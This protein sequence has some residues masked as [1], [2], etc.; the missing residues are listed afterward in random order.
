MEEDSDVLKRKQ[1][2]ILVISE[3][4]MFLLVCLAGLVSRIS[5][6]MK[7]SDFSPLLEKGVDAASSKNKNKKDKQKRNKSPWQR[8]RVTTTMKKRRIHRRENNI[9]RRNEN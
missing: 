4:R 1:Q 5:V 7:N 3:K 6:N 9:R 8:T 2:P